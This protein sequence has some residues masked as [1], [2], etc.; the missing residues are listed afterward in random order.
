MWFSSSEQGLETLYKLGSRVLQVSFPGQANI[1]P[2]P[3][4]MTYRAPAHCGRTRVD[5]EA[6]NCT[7]SAAQ[8][9]VQNMVWV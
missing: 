4:V 7:L 1:V 8:K 2:V 9:S 3:H 6:L 5:S